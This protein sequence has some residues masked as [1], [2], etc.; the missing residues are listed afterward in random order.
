MEGKCTEIF[1]SIDFRCIIKVGKRIYNFSIR[2]QFYI[3]NAL[4]SV[5]C[6]EICHILFTCSGGWP[7][8]NI[9]DGTK[10]SLNGEQFIQE[11]LLNSPAFFSIDQ[12]ISQTDRSKRSLYVCIILENK[13]ACSLCMNTY[14]VGD[15]LRTDS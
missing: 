9:S 13:Q 6:M 1:I 15:E 5:H 4:I 8:L 14:N 3:V 7:L 11:K 2:Q 12:Y 10:W